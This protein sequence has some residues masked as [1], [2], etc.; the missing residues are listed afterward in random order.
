MLGGEVLFSDFDN[1]GMTSTPERRRALVGD[2]DRVK[3]APRTNAGI[4]PC[5]AINL[6]LPHLRA[7]ATVAVIAVGGIGPVVVQVLRSSTAYRVVAIDTNAVRLQSVKNS[8]ADD[9]LVSQA[10]PVTDPTPCGLRARSKLD[11]VGILANAI[12]A[13]YGALVAAGLGTGSFLVVANAS[14]ALAGTCRDER[15]L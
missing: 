13:R 15:D 6:A 11:V 7:A 2:R 3:A 8:G 5:R 14:T 10:T 9:G 4:A 1:W 12:V